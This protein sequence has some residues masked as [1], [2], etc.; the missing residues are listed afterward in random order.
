MIPEAAGPAG[1]C[2]RLAPDEDG[3]APPPPDASYWIEAITRSADWVARSAAAARPRFSVSRASA[4]GAMAS[5]GTASLA[6]L[7]FSR[8]VCARAG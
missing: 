7:A 2:P 6:A 3:E 1:R 4:S 8:S 5:C